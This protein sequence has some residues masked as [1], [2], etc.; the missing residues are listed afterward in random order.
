N[1]IAECAHQLL[2]VD[3]PDA[4]DHPGT[5]VLLD[6][7]DRRR[8]RRFE[9]RGS[10]LDTVGAVVDPDSARLDE[11]AGRDHRCVTEDGDQVALAT[12]F[13]AQHAEPVLF[14]MEGD[15]LDEP[16]QDLG[17]RAGGSGLAASRYDGDE[18]PPAL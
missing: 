8:C 4:T 10:E 17:W 18:D 13:D 15:A 12:G 7:L 5:K 16:G 1:G 14:V 11:L 6:A 2:C 9:E 3:R